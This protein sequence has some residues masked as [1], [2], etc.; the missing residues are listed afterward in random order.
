MG[1]YSLKKTQIAT[2]GQ[3]WGPKLLINAQVMWFI[4]LNVKLNDNIKWDYSYNGHIGSPQ[5]SYKKPKNASIMSQGNA[6]CCAYWGY[7]WN[8]DYSKHLFCRNINIYVYINPNQSINKSSL[9]LSAILET[10]LKGK[11][12]ILIIAKNR[13]ISAP[14]WNWVKDVPECLCKL[15]GEQSK[16]WNKTIR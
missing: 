14:P 5:L 15:W 4:I 3:N 9:I 8:Y 13:I 16:F 2:T 10:T 12:N 11:N 6:N 7:L 1:W